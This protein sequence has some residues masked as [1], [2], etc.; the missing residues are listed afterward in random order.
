MRLTRWD[1]ATLAACTAAVCSIAATAGALRGQEAEATRG[2]PNVEVLSHTPLGAPM[3]VAD[4]ELEQEL[5]RP[6]AYV[7]RLLDAGF[8]VMDLS[9]PA[10]PQV[11]YEWR[12]ENADLHRGIGA[13]DAKYFKH[14]GRYYF[15][16]SFQFFPGGP[17]GDL[18]AIVF[19]VTDLPDA[20]KVKEVGR[21]RAPDYPTGFH[22]IFMYK[23]SDGRPLLFTTTSG[24]FVNVY[25]MA[26][27]LDG[28]EAYGLV[29]QIPV[30]EGPMVNEV[31]INGYHDFYVGFD[32]GTGQDKFYGGGAGGYY[33]YDITNLDDMTLVASVTGVP[34]VTWGH[35]ITPTPDGRYIVGETEYQYAPL[36]IFD[37]QPALDGEVATVR[38]PISAWTAN[39]ENLA[40]NHEVRWPYVFVSAY[41]DGLQIFNMRDPENPHTVAYYDTYDGP[42]AVGMCSDKVCNGAFGVDVRNA[43]G[44]IV[45]SDM[46]TG[47]WTF[48]WEGFEGWNGHDWGMPDI[49]SAQDWDNGP[50]RVPVTADADAE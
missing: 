21:I 43:D 37:L 27:F 22:N 23:H 2:T 34:G 30:P 20:S 44:L 36:R 35:T 7:A 32:P 26:R 33:V 19:D 15:V 31:G 28:D 40:H 25:D 42:H 4:L 50:Q 17:D 1:A 3:T 9:D 39:W 10:S 24:P 13:M 38:L 16:Q 14:D 11:I 47:F 45:I 46:S 49:S 41:E 48:R 6:Y 8:D 18:G 5:S 12:I 29:A